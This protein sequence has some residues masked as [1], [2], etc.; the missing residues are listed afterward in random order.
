MFPGEQHL[1]G[2]LPALVLQH[3]PVI[4]NIDGQF[5]R[6]NEMKSPQLHSRKRHRF[7]PLQISYLHESLTTDG[8]S[9]SYWWNRP[10]SIFIWCFPE[11]GY[12]TCLTL[13]L[14]SSDSSAF[15]WSNLDWLPYVVSFFPN[16]E[17]MDCLIIIIKKHERT[18]NPHIFDGF[19]MFY[20]QIYCIVSPQKKSIFS[21][22]VDVFSIIFRVQLFYLFG[23]CYN[24]IQQL[25]DLY[26]LVEFIPNIPKLKSHMPCH[27]FI[28][29]SMGIHGSQ[30]LLLGTVGYWWL[31]GYHN[32]I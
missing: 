26:P 14:F 28:S 5:W 25:E 4:S 23:D 24:M 21:I 9:P 19:T 16:S 32:C 2:Q 6:E 27:G 15:K 7:F 22:V 1:I 31:S 3:Q 10:L 30:W 11:L 12:L 8:F 13:P 17:I 20:Q 18:K 29:K